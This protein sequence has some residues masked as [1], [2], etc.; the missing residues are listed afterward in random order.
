MAMLGSAC[1]A[2][3]GGVTC[4]SLASQDEIIIQLSCED[5]YRYTRET[6]T[7][8]D[9]RCPVGYTRAYTGFFPGNTYAG[10]YA[11][12]RVGAASWRYVFPLGAPICAD[13][14]SALLPDVYKNPQI[15]LTAIGS[16]SETS[17]SYRLEFYF[18]TLLYCDFGG[19]NKRA[20]PD[21]DCIARSS[22]TFCVPASTSVFSEVDRFS[23]FPTVV[24]VDLSLPSPVLIYSGNNVVIRT[25][26]G[27]A[28]KVSREIIEDTGSSALSVSIVL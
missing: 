10:T 17:C 13:P 2:C 7:V 12:S 26:S 8:A 15:E 5:R 6:V 18:T 19:D 25:C 21:F 27:A 16:S 9:A 1:S 11:L 20:K 28:E 14:L 4:A 22:T 24:S 3:C 23:L